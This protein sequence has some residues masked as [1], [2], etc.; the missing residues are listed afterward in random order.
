MN[1]KSVSIAIAM[2]AALLTF[3]HAQD[4]ESDKDARDRA[5]ARREAQL[6]AP[7]LESVAPKHK[8]SAEEIAKELANPATPLSSLGNTLE[9]REFE[10]NLPG[11]D[12]EE[13]WV[14][15]FQPSFPFSVGEGA[16][17]ALRPAFPLVIDQPVPAAGGG[18]IDEGPELGDI[19]FDFIYG[20]TAPNGL[21]TLGGMFG[22]LPTHTDSAVGSDQWRFGPEALIGVAKKWGVVGALVFHQ[23]DVAGG[24]DEPS[25]SLSSINYLY[26]IGL[27]NAYQ[28]ASGPIITYD[29]QANSDDAWTVPLGTGL[30]KTIIAGQ[31]PIKLQGQVFYFVEQPDSFGPEWGFKLSV[32]PVVKNPFVRKK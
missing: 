20:K 12:G 15:S 8:K 26:A 13:S 24:S 1:A 30:A 22:V 17:L 32:S 31:M 2:I 16:I 5:R 7:G 3:A 23:W 18:F 6:A 28:L 14:Y 4:A 11:A 10:G 25:T 29:W 27:G 21:I 19:S 9:Y